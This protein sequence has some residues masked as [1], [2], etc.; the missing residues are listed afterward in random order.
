MPRSLVAVR[1]S[2]KLTP[3]TS[4]L[5]ALE[6]LHHMKGEDEYCPG[7]FYGSPSHMHFFGLG[8]KLLAFLQVFTHASWRGSGFDGGS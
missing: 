2:Q 3:R 5:G 8:L 7:E 6:D 1:C 4:H